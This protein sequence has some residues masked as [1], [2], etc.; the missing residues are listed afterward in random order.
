MYQIY[1]RHVLLLLVMASCCSALSAQAPQR[2]NYQ[3]VLRDA[4]DQNAIVANTNVSITF[5][6]RETTPDGPLLFSETQL[7][8]TND[9]GLINLRVGEVEDLSAVDW[10]GFQKFLT[11]TANV[12]GGADMLVGTIPLVSVP[13]ALY[14]ENVNLS[15]GPGIS[16]DNQTVEN[17]GDLS[18]TNEIQHLALDGNTLSLSQSDIT[19]EL[20]TGADDW[21]NQAAETDASLSG[22][23]TPG[24]PLGLS[25]QGALTGQVL[26]WNGSQW[27]PQDDDSEVYVQGNGISVADNVIT[28]TGDADPNDD[29]MIGS[30]AGGDLTGAF[31]N[32]Q[33][34]NGAVTSEAI[35]NGSIQGTDLS[36][37]GAQ[38][39]Q[40]LQWN[41]AVW[42]PADAAST[43]IQAGNGISI[44]GT[45]ISNSGDTD[46][47]DD[48]TQGSAAGGD[49]TGTYPNPQIAAGSIQGADLSSMGAQ[50]GQVL[51]YNGTIW[52]PADPASTVFQAG[53]GI[54]INGNTI[55][56]SGD[57][58]AS[59]DITQGSAAG[60][61]LIGT[62]PNPQ[63]APSSIDSDNILDGSIQGADLASMSAQTGQVLQYNGI[64]WLPATI[65]SQSLSAGSGISIN[66]DQIINTGDTNASDDITV[67]SP[68]GGDLTGFFPNPQ[69]QE[70]A[71]DADAIADGSIGSADIADGTLQLEDLSSMGATPG[72]VLSWN[73][74]AWETTSLSEGQAYMAGMG[75]AINGDTISALKDSSLWNAY[76]LR[77]RPIGGMGP[78]QGQA[79][80]YDTLSGEWGATSPRGD[81]S[82]GWDSLSVVG[83]RGRPIGGM[84]P[85]QGQAL[86]YDTLDGEW[87]ATS[88]TGD[89]GGTFAELTVVGLQ[90]NQLAPATVNPG[91]GQALVF[92]DDGTWGPVA[93]SGDLSG[94]WLEPRV[95]TLLGA[96]F[97]GVT[98]GEG[99]LFAIQGGEWTSVTISGDVSGTFDNL[100]LSFPINETGSFGGVP[101]LW[102]T[103]NLQV[104]IRGGSGNNFGVHGTTSHS[105]G[106]LGID[107]DFLDELTNTTRAGVFGESTQGG[108]NDGIGV[109]GRAINGS[110]SFGIGGVFDG[111]YAGAVGVMYSNGLAG[112]AGVGAFDNESI[113]RTTGGILGIAGGAD[114]GGSFFGSS[115][116]NG[117]VLGFADGARFGGLMFGPDFSNPASR[118]AGL[119]TEQGDSDYA[120]WIHDDY[121]ADADNLCGFNAIRID[122]PADP[123]NQTLRHYPVYTPEMKTIYD[124][125]VTTDS[126]GFATVQL[127]DYFEDMNE[128]FRYH[129]TVIGVFAQA[130]VAEKVTNN[131]FVIQTDQPQVEVSWQVTGIRKDPYALANR[132]PSAQPKT[133]HEVGTYIHPEVYDPNYEAEPVEVEELNIGRN[134]E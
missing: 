91:E 133:G 85:A 86:V 79:L 42:A 119:Y 23:G 78:A 22:D 34:A 55:S 73:G 106:G 68:V 5:E 70:G 20:P 14:A 43:Q 46:A 118:T 36:S 67:G 53:D 30:P 129:L 38:N 105:N 81:L 49:L 47:S 72:Q 62:Y 104:G 132:R 111:R 29:I 65:N 101:M 95:E 128:N 44:N 7:T 97:S 6:I 130:I 40:V 71:V 9:L 1:L 17:T 18:N 61:E 126:E 121:C 76:A 51:Q 16:L 64:S 110:E 89:L 103:N 93:P 114:Y 108:S 134:N 117:G 11:I 48:I 25:P 99:E 80:V 124:G 60:G 15:A 4:N 12:D 32:P 28:N 19:I 39:G 92:L 113:S 37:M 100:E 122:H 13:Y 120:A 2:I 90:G 27:V 107:E 83:L 45:T 3:A 41:G 131:Q 8:N 21:G 112:L 52:V 50:N 125:V 59:D 96:S 31:P 10:S 87:G 109:W 82:G 69:L 74:A 35:A 84:S 115:G 77:G 88:P 58:N 63:I 54:T 33:L 102:L 57:T 56:N 123:D 98:P 94:T 66:N 75:I 26:K 127:P 24:N 116:Q